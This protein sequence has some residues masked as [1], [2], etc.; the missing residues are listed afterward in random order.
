MIHRADDDPT[1]LHQ[2]PECSCS[3]EERADL[4]TIYCWTQPDVTGTDSI[5]GVARN[6]QP[7][8]LMAYCRGRVVSPE[9]RRYARFAAAS[10]PE[11]TV[12]LKRFALAETLEAL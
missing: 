12:R 6:G 1:K 9:F 2:H 5:I 4:Q 8:F 11:R 7:V 3:D 10:Y